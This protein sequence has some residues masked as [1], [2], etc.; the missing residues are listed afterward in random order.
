MEASSGVYL[1][2]RLYNKM[3]AAADPFAYD[4]YRKERVT[5][6]REEAASSRIR[7]T[8][9]KVVKRS[10]L[11]PSLEAAAAD[12]RFGNELFS[13]P[14]FS[15]DRNSETF[16]RLNPMGFRSTPKVRSPRHHRQGSCLVMLIRARVCATRHFHTGGCVRPL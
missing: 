8:K 2:L 11:Q 1:D 13:D 16:K 14:A 10:D 6:L 4:R 12:P 3:K 15:I 9:K 5:A 7:A